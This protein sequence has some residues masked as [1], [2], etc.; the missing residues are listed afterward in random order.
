MRIRAT[1]TPLLLM[2]TAWV[3]A[4]PAAPLPPAKILM[5]YDGTPE[6]SVVY[7]IPAIATV[8]AG[9]HEGRL[10]AIADY[11]HCGGDIGA[12]RIDL[13]LCVSDDNGLTWTAPDDLRDADGNPVARGTG[14]GTTETSL[15]HPDCG[16]GDA[17]LVADSESGEVL[18]MSVCGRTN[19]WKGRRNN[20][21]QVARWYS[22]DGG[23][24]WTP[25]ENITEQ[26]YSLFDGNIPAGFIDSMFFGSGRIAQSSRIKTGKYYRL[27]AV[28]SGWNATTNVMANWVL[29]SDDLGRTWSVLGDPAIAPVPARGDEPKAEELP[30]G[31]V[32]LSARGQ[33]TYGRNFNIFRYTDAASAQGEWGEMST[34]PIDGINTTPCDGEV[35]ILPAIRTADNAEVNLMLQ[36]VPFSN[37]REKVGIAYKALVTPED[38]ASPAA[39]GSNWEGHIE[40]TEKPSGYSTMSLQKD[41]QIAF[42]FEETTFPGHDYCMLYMPLSIETITDGKYRLNPN[43]K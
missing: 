33:G 43:V 28:L 12:G 35:M 7:R 41:G 29:Y 20:P 39:V 27:Y 42:F 23:A 14:L 37:K 6:H 22:Y 5:Q 17:A 30:D 40:V 9:E 1:I 26:I 2:T 16:F 11:R 4:A 32:L 21:N 18:L 25:F 24:T 34:Q 13:H 38:W 31:S 8:G 36:S 19:L 15:Q 10:L 3:T